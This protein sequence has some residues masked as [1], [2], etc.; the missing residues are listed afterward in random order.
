MDLFAADHLRLNLLVLVLLF[1]CSMWDQVNLIPMQQRLNQQ[2]LLLILL[3]TLFGIK[4]Q[5]HKKYQLTI[6]HIPYFQLQ[7]TYELSRF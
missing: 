2:V 6:K 1:K 3:L 5:I 7:A 4:L